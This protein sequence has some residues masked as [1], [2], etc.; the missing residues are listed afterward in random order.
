MRDQEKL[1]KNHQRENIS[2]RYKDN[3]SYQAKQLQV[4][5][6]WRGLRMAANKQR[7][8]LAHYHCCWHI[9]TAVGTD[10]AH[11]GPQLTITAFSTPLGP[12]AAMPTQGDHTRYQKICKSL[13]H[14]RFAGVQMKPFCRRGSFARAATMPVVSQN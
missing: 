4:P 9:I 7:A 1:E 10:P 5:W 3:F 12:A 8:L 14:W 6:S 13:K 2:A 11:C